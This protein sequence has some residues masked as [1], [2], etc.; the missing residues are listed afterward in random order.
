MHSDTDGESGHSIEKP[1]E[2]RDTF[3]V[4]ESQPADNNL[5]FRDVI[6]TTT[7]P[8]GHRVRSVPRELFTKAIKASQGN[9]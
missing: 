5:S 4:R 3:V 6:K 1:Q 2:R 7:L 8:G 9:K